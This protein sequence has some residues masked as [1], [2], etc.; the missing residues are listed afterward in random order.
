MGN[1]AAKNTGNPVFNYYFLNL[2]IEEEYQYLST[3]PYNIPS[4]T[5]TSRG[6]G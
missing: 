5:Y 4:A 6:H 1:G 3:Y 2:T